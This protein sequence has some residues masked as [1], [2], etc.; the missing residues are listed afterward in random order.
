MIAAGAPSLRLPTIHEVGHLVSL[1]MMDCADLNATQIPGRNTQHI[2]VTIAN[3][4]H[5]PDAE[6]RAQ[7]TDPCAPIYACVP[8]LTSL[9]TCT[10]SLTYSDW[11]SFSMILFDIIVSGYLVIG[12]GTF[13]LTHFEPTPGFP[14][15]G[16]SWNYDSI[17]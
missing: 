8:F 2:S 3:L 9:G 14:L 7:W 10:I 4:N 13:L 1:F 16:G 15:G 5:T 6:A 17:V 12:S 11:Y